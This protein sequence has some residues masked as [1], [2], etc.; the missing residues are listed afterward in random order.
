MTLACSAQSLA[1]DEPLAGTAPVVSCYIVI[2]QPGL[3]RCASW[4]AAGR[5][6]AVMGLLS[7]EI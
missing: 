1:V 4:I 6:A 3:A 7:K 5:A 2:E